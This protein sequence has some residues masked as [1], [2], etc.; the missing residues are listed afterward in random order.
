MDRE[1]RELLVSVLKEGVSN[2]FDRVVYLLIACT[3][4]ILGG[5]AAIFVLGLPLFIADMTGHYELDGKILNLNSWVTYVTAAW[6]GGCLLLMH[7]IQK[8]AD[9][10]SKERSQE[11]QS[12][13]QPS[14]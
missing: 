8:V 13:D 5:G 2:S 6:F 7:E 12:P 10:K 14:A 3:V 9:R 4:Y 1:K 11:E